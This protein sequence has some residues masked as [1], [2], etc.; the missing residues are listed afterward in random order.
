MTDDEMAQ[1][2][3]QDFVGAFGGSVRDAAHALCVAPTTLYDWDKPGN[4]LTER[5]RH[6]MIG[7]IVKTRRVKEFRRAKKS[8][9]GP[10]AA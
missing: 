9:N 5:Q 10:L 1:I 8:N 7:A 2:T 3:K 6:E 4:P